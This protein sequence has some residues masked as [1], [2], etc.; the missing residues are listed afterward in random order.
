MKWTDKDT[1]TILFLLKEGK[2]YKEISKVVGRNES[3]IRSKLFKIGE[4][5][6]NHVDIPKEREHICLQCNIKFY[7]LPHIDRKFCSKSCLRTYLNYNNS[8]N[9]I[10]NKT[11]QKCKNC[12]KEVSNKYCNYKCQ[13]EYERKII[14]TKIENGDGNFYISVYKKYL[15]EK[16]GEKCMDCGWNKVHPVTNKVPIQIEHIDGNSTNN[17]LENLKILCPNC[18]SLTLTYGALNKGN[19]RKN[20]KR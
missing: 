8:Y 18:H 11:K 15:I 16:F 3:S 9:D 17:N 20:R 14:Y 10:K 6:T 19:G 13:K 5:W 4:K 12:N 7:D 1:E 2:T